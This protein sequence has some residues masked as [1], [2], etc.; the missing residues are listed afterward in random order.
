MPKKKKRKKK[1]GHLVLQNE[2]KHHS[3]KLPHKLTASSLLHRSISLLHSVLSS[4]VFALLSCWQHVSF[5]FINDSNYYSSAGI[6]ETPRGGFQTGENTKHCFP[7][8]VYTDRGQGL[9]GRVKVTDRMGIYLLF[10][11]PEKGGE[12]EEKR[13]FHQ[14]ACSC[15]HW[16]SHIADSFSGLG[17]L[18]ALSWTNI[19][20]LIMRHRGL[21]LK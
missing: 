4:F 1:T 16:I 12:G 10:L 21:D 19:T 15:I 2:S 17:K 14:E 9:G 18:E 7:S 6:K 20:V 3:C 13:G 8:S 5:C 11:I